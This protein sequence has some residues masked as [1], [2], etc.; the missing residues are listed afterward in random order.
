[1]TGTVSV[2]TGIVLG[3]LVLLMSRPR[4][5]DETGIPVFSRLPKWVALN[6]GIDGGAALVLGAGGLI[7]GD[8]CWQNW[9]GAALG[10]LPALFW[11][12]FAVGEFA[13][14]H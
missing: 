12:V 9:A 3:L 8:R 5:P 14:P 11:V 7:R 6:F 4:I 13:Y 1:M 2:V 10:A